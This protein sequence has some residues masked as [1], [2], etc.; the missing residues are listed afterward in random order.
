MHVFRI[1]CLQLPTVH[2]SYQLA[3]GCK[4]AQHTHP[5]IRIGS[6]GCWKGCKTP[7]APIAHL[8]EA[9]LPME[10]LAIAK[11]LCKWIKKYAVH[12]E[13]SFLDA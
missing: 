8:L 4:Y 10:Y 11:E 1:G 6:F 2:G 5:R 3:L 13:G 9:D 12:F 7:A